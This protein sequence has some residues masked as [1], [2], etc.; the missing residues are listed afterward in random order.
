MSKTKT[1]KTKPTRTA[2]TTTNQRAPEAAPELPL[3]AFHEIADWVFDLAAPHAAGD[4]N[5]RRSLERVRRTVHAAI[6]GRRFRRLAE[7]DVLTALSLIVTAAE[8][9]LGL[10][11]IANVP[12]AVLAAL[13]HSPM[14]GGFGGAHDH[15]YPRRA[16]SLAP[17]MRCIP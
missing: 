16:P 5:A 17:F 15:A 7:I 9:D 11:G 3:R 10:G 6:D 2:R 4:G 12:P 13:A 14:P 1:S 8:H